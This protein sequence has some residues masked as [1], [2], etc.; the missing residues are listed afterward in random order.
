LNTPK[1]YFSING[2]SSNN[3]KIFITQS[4]RFEK[5]R[6]KPLTEHLEDFKQNLLNKGNTTKHV[7]LTYNRAKKIVDG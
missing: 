5:D 7:N 6:L 2:K 1:I 4:D 3:T